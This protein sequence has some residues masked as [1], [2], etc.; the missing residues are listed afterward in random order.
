MPF[1]LLLSAR[2]FTGAEAA[3]MG[4]VNRSFASVEDMQAHV[5]EASA[6]LAQS[7]SPRSMAIMK[8]QMRKAYFQ[9]YEEALATADAEM[10]GSF[11]TDDFR[12]GVD[13][14]VERRAPNFK[15]V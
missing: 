15:P 13:S 6:Q 5:A 2:K 11:A 9:S 3:E 8:A 4:M 10:K 14:F 12:E 1:D 7:A